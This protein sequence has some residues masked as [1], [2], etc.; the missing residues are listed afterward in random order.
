MDNT[1]HILDHKMSRRS[2]LT[3][4]A[5]TSGALLTP[6][7]LSACGGGAAGSGSQVNY[8]L[9]W[10]KISQYAGFFAGEQNGYYKHQGIVPN[11]ISGGPTVSPSLI[12][13]AGHAAAGD[14]DNVAILQAIDKGAPLVMIGAL[15][16]PE[17]Y[18]VY[19]YPK[20]PILT[21]QE[22]AHKT[23]A[24]YAATQAQIKPLLTRAGV[25]VSTVNFVPPG[26][27]PTSFIKHTVDG[28]FGSPVYTEGVAIHEAGLHPLFASFNK[29]FFPVY[30]N[31]IITTHNV[32]RHQRA[33]LVKF[34][35]ASVQGWEWADLH[36]AAAAKLT[37]DKYGAS[38]LNLRNET[39][40]M[41]LQASSGTLR[42]SNG[43]FLTIDPAVIEK[44]ITIA[45]SIGIIRSQ[46]SVSRIVDTSILSDA[47]GG[48]TT[49]PL[50]AGAR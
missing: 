19:S 31:P 47:Y 41:E 5:A 22:F 24:A 6:S 28:Y 3:A 18:G 49:L 50:A 44:Q 7:L 9:G 27:D 29:L 8:Q 25:K 1:S 35:R 10:I 20:K 14:D 13:A 34:M 26:V 30:G 21:L 48:K 36:P 15:L 17:S 4:A 38:G 42:R 23:I 12:V 11:F 45:H 33:Q 2:L 37:V 39:L 16:Y 46:P 40:S 43:Q 32:I